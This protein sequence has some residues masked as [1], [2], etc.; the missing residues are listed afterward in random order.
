[1]QQDQDN[2]QFDVLLKSSATGEQPYIDNIEE[3]RPDPDHIEIC[4]RWFRDQDVAVYATDF[5]LAGETSRAI[6][7]KLFN[8]KLI[9]S[10]SGNISSG[11][12]VEGTLQ[13]PPPIADYI[14][15]I[16]LITPPELF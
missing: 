8:V 7:E 1:M 3:F 9:Q 5:G 12:I 4:L 10:E 6:F 14:D 13:I 16:T 11:W 15:Q 2:I